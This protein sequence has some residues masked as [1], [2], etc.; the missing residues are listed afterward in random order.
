VLEL[1][2]PHRPSPP[3]ARSA[4]ALADRCDDCQTKVWLGLLDLPAAFPTCQVDL[5][6]C[7]E[8]DRL[9][10]AVRE[11][12]RNRLADAMVPALNRVD[13]PALRAALLRAVRELE[14][15]DCI[16]AVVLEAANE[17]LSSTRPS[18]FMLASIQAS[19]HRAEGRPP[20]SARA[21]SR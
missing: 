14:A 4:A 21:L 11:D 10:A 13:H 15:A 3:G 6:S 9:R 18:M 20:P 8:V 19:A 5:P 16:D 17:D 7:A 12:D 1:P 2:A